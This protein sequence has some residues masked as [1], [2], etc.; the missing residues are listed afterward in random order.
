MQMDIEVL[1]A[2]NLNSGVEADGGLVLIP[3]DQTTE[4]N[5]IKK[6]IY[7]FKRISTFENK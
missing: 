5:G 6:N 1:E 3:V 4:I 7:S 2:R